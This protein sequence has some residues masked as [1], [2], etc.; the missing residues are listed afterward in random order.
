M[1]RNYVSLFGSGGDVL[2]A[3]A[4]GGDPYWANVTFL[5]IYES[6]KA[7]GNTS[8]DDAS[9]NNLTIDVNGAAQWDTAQFPS[10]A[11]ASALHGPLNTDFLS[12]AANAAFG[13]GTGD[14][15]IE[16]YARFDLLDQS[17][18]VFSVG[19]GTVLEVY[20]LTDGTLNLWGGSAGDSIAGSAGD[21]LVDT[22]YHLAISR[23]SGNMRLFK[24]GTQ[25]GSTDA[26]TAD[27][28]A[29]QK[30][31]MGAENSGTEF[32]EGWLHSVRVT[33]GVGRYTSNFTPPTIPL[34]TS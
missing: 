8:F 3:A 32:L 6:G 33:K 9:T 24:D 22:W 7:D 28:G 11:D 10:G 30:F 2:P 18:A 15:T 27:Y 34:P 13:F 5:G 4:G 21:I 26:N 1:P 29:S 25:I 31:Y 17:S 20:S 19:T 16:C 23:A 12:V 14:F